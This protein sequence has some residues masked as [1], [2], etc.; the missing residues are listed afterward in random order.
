MKVEDLLRYLEGEDPS[1]DVASFG[2]A[3]TGEIVVGDVLKGCKLKTP[4]GSWVVLV[5]GTVEQEPS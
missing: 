2:R 1:S 5:V 3:T 4:K